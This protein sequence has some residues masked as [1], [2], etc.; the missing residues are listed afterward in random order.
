MPSLEI[1][2]YSL[3]RRIDFT[4]LVIRLEAFKD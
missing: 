4:D 2:W 1:T 3:L